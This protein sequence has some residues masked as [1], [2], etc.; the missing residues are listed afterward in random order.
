[1]K[2]EPH[3]N[4]FFYNAVDNSGLVDRISPDSGVYKEPSFAQTT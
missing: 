2:D 1:M 4:F 3:N